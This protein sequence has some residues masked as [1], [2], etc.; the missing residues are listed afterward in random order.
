MP[1]PSP[2]AMAA[3]SIEP[4][5]IFTGHLTPEH[6][7]RWACVWSGKCRADGKHFFDKCA[8]IGTFDFCAELGND[9]SKT[10]KFKEA[11]VHTVGLWPGVN[12]RGGINRAV[13]GLALKTLHKFKKYPERHRF[14]D[15]IL[16]DVGG[17]LPDALDLIEQRARVM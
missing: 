1:S 10:M 14:W 3:G 8:V 2:S 6:V 13:Y 17:T 12:R 16:D 11:A 15:G 9:F 7:K 5:V 4:A